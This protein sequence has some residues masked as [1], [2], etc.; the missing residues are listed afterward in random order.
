MLDQPVESQEGED[1]VLR[2]FNKKLAARVVKF[3]L[4]HL[5]SKVY[6]YDSHTRL[7]NIINN[8]A[9]YGFADA[10]SVSTAPFTMTQRYQWTNVDLV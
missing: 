9:K 7:L 3:Q 8:F 2:Q 5:D 1:V 10:T 6:L 4:T